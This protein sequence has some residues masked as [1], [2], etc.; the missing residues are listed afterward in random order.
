MAQ[1]RA[2]LK[3]QFK[4]NDFLRLADRFVAAESGTK[5]TTGRL[6]LFARIKPRERAFLRFVHHT[7]NVEGSDKK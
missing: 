4:K 3:I 2:E 1:T 6:A 7:Y 5:Q